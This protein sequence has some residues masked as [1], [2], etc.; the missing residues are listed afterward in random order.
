MA[1]KFCV[2]EQDVQCW[3]K[4]KGLLIKEENSTQKAWS[5]S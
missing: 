4:Q 3:R 1:Q 2:A 5:N